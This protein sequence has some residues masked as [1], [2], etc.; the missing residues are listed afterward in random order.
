MFGKKAQLQIQELQK[1]NEL[2]K[3]QNEK[4]AKRKFSNRKRL[5]FGLT[6]K[7]KDDLFRMSVQKGIDDFKVNN[8]GKS[9]AMDNYVRTGMKDIF[10]NRCMGLNNIF[11]DYFAKQGFIGY[12]ACAILAQ[13]WLIS[14]CCSLPLEDAIAAG[15]EVA[16]DNTDKSSDEMDK[17]KDLSSKLYQKSKEMDLDSILCKYGT[18]CRTFGVSYALPIVKGIDYSKPFNIDG[19]RQGSYKGIKIIDPCWI[20]P[21]FNQASLMTPADLDFYEPTYYKTMNGELIHKS[22]LVKCIY[23]PVSDILKP[24]YFFGGVSLSQMIYNSVFSAEMIADE[25]PQLVR[26]KR[27]YVL[28]GD[29]ESLIMNPEEA[30]E[31][32]EGFVYFRDNYQAVVKDADD[33]VKQLDT[34]MSDLPEVQVK[35]YQRVCAVAGVPYERIMATNPSGSNASGEYTTR[36]YVQLLNSIREMHLKSL[37]NKHYELLLKSEFNSKE[38]FDVLFKPIDS[39]TAVETA[40]NAAIKVNTLSTAVQSG[41]I[42]PDNMRDALKNMAELGLQNI[43]DDIPMDTLNPA[44]NPFSKSM[45]VGKSSTSPTADPKRST[46]PVSPIT[47]TRETFKLREQGALPSN[48][49]A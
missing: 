34:S 19:V 49:K 22:H 37:L 21:E 18:N 29:L 3:Q 48:Q 20:L 13:H 25:I 38:K 31:R 8:G 26:S 4:L 14:K 40:Q 5:S 9:V 23:A 39:P 17:L 24:S 1:Q 11:Y 7:Q 2:L 42:S 32:L 16:M 33:D 6:D 12:Q 10:S 44:E 15:H 30:E 46:L 43:S 47:Q 27:M 35:A 45:S 28:D 41:A 36:T